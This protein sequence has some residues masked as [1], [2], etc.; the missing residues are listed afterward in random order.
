M[1]VSTKFDEEVSFVLPQDVRYETAFFFSVLLAI[2]VCFA[3]WAYRDA[4][5]RGSSGISAFLLV[6]IV[7]FPLGLIVWICIRHR[8]ERS[9]A[10]QGEERGRSARSC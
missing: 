2:S 10:E 8:W 3:I 7:P 1:Q 9:S 4:L 6:L 5:N